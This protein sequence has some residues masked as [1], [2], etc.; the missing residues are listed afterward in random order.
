MPEWKSMNIT[1]DICRGVYLNRK[2]LLQLRVPE[3]EPIQEE[4]V[5]A[6]PTEIDLNKEESE[7]E[8]EPVTIEK[9]A[10]NVPNEPAKEVVDV[11]M[12]DAPADE[13]MN[14][15]DD[16]VDEDENPDTQQSDVQPEQQQQQLSE[17]SPKDQLEDA[18]HN[19]ETEADKPQQETPVQSEAEKLQSETEKKTFKKPVSK[20]RKATDEINLKRSSKRLK[21]IQK[22]TKE[23]YDAL[24]DLIYKKK[25]SIKSQNSNTITEVY[26]SLL[27]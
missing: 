18:S 26:D 21:P 4:P 10:T 17:A 11:D 27:H 13:P 23:L 9:E 14:Q 25:A 6:Q 7:V 2:V 1:I 15:A 8:Q 22:S 19:P 20:K 12:T 3:P 24:H 16:P 5:V